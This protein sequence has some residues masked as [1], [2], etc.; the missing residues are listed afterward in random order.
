[1]LVVAL[2]PVSLGTLTATLAATPAVTL[3]VTFGVSLI[4][5]GLNTARTM[6]TL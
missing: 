3:V 6:R 5:L 4:I 2:A 1:M